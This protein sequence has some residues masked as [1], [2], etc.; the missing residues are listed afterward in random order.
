MTRDEALARTQTA[1]DELAAALEQGRSQQLTDY[2][3]L[4]ARFHRYSSG[5]VFLIHVQRPSA[6]HIA[7]F[8]TW[9]QLGRHVRKGEKGIAILA[10]MIGRS[11]RQ[12]RNLPEPA[13]DRDS[14]QVLRGFRV[15]HVFDVVQTDGEMLPEFARVQGTPDQHLFRLRELIQQQGIMLEHDFLPG[16]ARGASLGGGIIVRPDLPPAEMLSVLAHELAHEMLHKAPAGPE[17]SLTQRETEAEA[18]AFVVASAIGLDGLD[19]TRDYIQLYR[20]NRQTL[21]DSLHRIQRTAT[22][23]LQDIV[24]AD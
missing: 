17:M 2:L 6:T 12:N 23:I 11:K 20:G 1:L 22:A 19:H 7:G 21:A 24:G 15:A 8:H 5:N 18:T 9:L 13:D 4:L 10:P 16:S 14:G 3:R